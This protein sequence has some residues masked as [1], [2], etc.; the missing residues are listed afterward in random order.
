MNT[1]TELMDNIKALQK[2]LD[3]V[4]GD[5]DDELNRS[6]AQQFVFETDK[7][8]EKS[9]PEFSEWLEENFGERARFDKNRGTDDKGVPDQEFD[10][11]EQEESG[12]VPTELTGTD[13]LKAWGEYEVLVDIAMK[14][15]FGEN[16]KVNLEPENKKMNITVWVDGAADASTVVATGNPDAI[17]AWSKMKNN[18]VSLSQDMYD[19]LD[20]KGIGKEGAEITIDFLNDNDLNKSLITCKNGECIYDCTE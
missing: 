20:D 13:N 8:D 1:L 17:A 4:Y 18:I 5:I 11:K 9:M 10:E 7:D 15:G 14:K 3:E 16:F 12:A 2:G 6:G 19:R